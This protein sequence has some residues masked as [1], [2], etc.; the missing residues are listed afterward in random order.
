MTKLNKEI[1]L[2]LT[3]GAVLLLILWLV[4][5][6]QKKQKMIEEL[7]IDRLKLIKDS[8]ENSDQITSEIKRQLN[9]LVDEYKNIDPEIS[10]ELI[11]ALSIINAGEEEKGVGCLSIIIEKMLKAKYL[12]HPKFCEWIKRERKKS[13]TKASQAD[14][15]EFAKFDD[16]I[17]KEEYHFANTVRTLRNGTFHEAG[18]KLS[19]NF[20]KASL[21]IGVELVLKIGQKLQLEG[22]LKTVSHG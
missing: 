6:N 3:V 18:K 22:T 1:A 8:I 15:I 21:L 11:T 5:E 9:K 4:T 13:A 7:E 14:L 19:W 12:K 16:L 20:S 17:T 10:A 2:G